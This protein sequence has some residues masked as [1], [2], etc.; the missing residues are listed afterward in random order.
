MNTSQQYMQIA[1]EFAAELRRRAASGIRQ[2]MVYGSVARGDSTETSDIDL[3][4][5]YAGNPLPGDIPAGV[6]AE[7]M[8]RH[9]TLVSVLDCSASE[10]ERLQRFPFGWQIAK[11]A[12][13]L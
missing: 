2:I 10:Y 5:V 6:A 8:D 4:V 13:T 12:I 9:N 11:E 7:M 3:L 1:R